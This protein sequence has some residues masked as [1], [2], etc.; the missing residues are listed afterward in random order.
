MVNKSRQ[1]GK[2]EVGNAEVSNH[3]AREAKKKQEKEKA[4]W[5]TLITRRQALNLANGVAQRVA[6][7]LAR[8]HHEQIRA[9]Y[10]GMRSTM[11][12]LVVYYA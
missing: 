9:I 1:V 12:A 7:N 2:S 6:D 3:V 4:Y 8:E 5:N 11:E 10:L